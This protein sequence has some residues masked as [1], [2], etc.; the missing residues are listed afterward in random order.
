M[1]TPQHW[2]YFEFLAHLYY[3]MDAA[4]KA[5]NQKRK[6]ANQPQGGNHHDAA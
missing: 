2:Q 3:E 4:L 6:H 5:R 1:L